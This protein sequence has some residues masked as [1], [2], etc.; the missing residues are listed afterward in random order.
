MIWGGTKFLPEKFLLEDDLQK[1]RKL[2]W[3]LCPKH[4]L[5]DDKAGAYAKFFNGGGGFK[6]DIKNLFAIYTLANK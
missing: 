5:G 3:F 4:S 2:R 1:L 6:S